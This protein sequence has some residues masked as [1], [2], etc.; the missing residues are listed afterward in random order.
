MLVLT[1]QFAA[2]AAKRCH[3]LLARQAAAHASMHPGRWS[4]TAQSKK[5]CLGSDFFTARENISR[6]RTYGRFTLFAVA[7]K[8]KR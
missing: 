8:V 5:L 6:G 4:G 7:N 2:V 1:A 3:A